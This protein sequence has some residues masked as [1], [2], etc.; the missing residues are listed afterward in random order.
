[1]A[2]TP[3]P[4][5]VLVRELRAWRERRGY[6]AQQL[7]DRT[8]GVLSRQ[9]ISKVENG[10]RRL[11]L[12]ELTALGVALNVSPLLLVLPLGR[13]ANVQ[14]LP[15]E[16]SPTWEVFKWWTGDVVIEDGGTDATATIGYFKDHDELVRTVQ[17]NRESGSGLAASWQDRLLDLRKNMRRAGVLPPALPAD[18]ADLNET[19]GEL[20]RGGPDQAD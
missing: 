14:I 5:E 11:T 10:D 12:N 4:E 13:E 15:G 3:S 9:A 17:W 6:T 1:M 7:A 8:K 20:S 16:T 18:L 2:E 19:E